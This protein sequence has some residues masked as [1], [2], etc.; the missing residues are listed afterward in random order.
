M[1]GR[2]ELKDSHHPEWRGTRS[3]TLERAQKELAQSIPPGRF[4]IFDRE[5]KKKI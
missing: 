3:T 2:Y 4:Y 1:K 5:T